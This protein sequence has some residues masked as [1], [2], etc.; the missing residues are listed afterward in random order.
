VIEAFADLP[1]EALR[2]AALPS[3]WTYL[4][5]VR[6]LALDVER[7]WFRSVAAG[8]EVELPSGA[9]AWQVPSDQP[10]QEIIDLYRAEA[11]TA[12]RIILSTPLDAEPA[13]SPT[14]QFGGMPSRALRRTVLHVITET[15]THAGQLDAARELIDGRQWLVLTE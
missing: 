5:L 1:D 11:P 8:E 4:G 3:G 6:H 2:T 7:F 14:Q 13:A 10:A 9:D 12:D 15:A